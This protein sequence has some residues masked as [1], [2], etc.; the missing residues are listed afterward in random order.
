M[1]EKLPLRIKSAADELNIVMSTEVATNVAQYLVELQKWNKTYNLTAVKRQED[2]LVQHVFDCLAILPALKKQALNK[3]ITF[4]T[5]V[6]VGSGAGIPGA[7]IALAQ[8]NMNVFCVDAVEK[9]AAF[10]SHVAGK[11]SVKNL[12]AVHGRI[13]QLEEFDADLVISRAFASLEDFAH[14]AGK[15]V[16][17]HGLMAAMKSRQIYTDVDELNKANTGWEVFCIDPLTVPDL[18]AERYLAWLRRETRNES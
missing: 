5:V 7:I 3:G 15:H 1:E 2:M 17:K 12:Q 14:L 10:V 4:K 8:P 6:D 9:K 11:L 13:E 18:H 16:G